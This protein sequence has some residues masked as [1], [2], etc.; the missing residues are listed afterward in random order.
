M[1]IF[2]SYVSLPEGNRK[3]NEHRYMGF[4][5]SKPC[6]IAARR[7]RIIKYPVQTAGEGFPLMFLGLWGPINYSYI[8]VGALEPWI[9]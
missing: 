3:L 7:K 5:S 4:L 1:V 6:G 2:H 9:F 8:L